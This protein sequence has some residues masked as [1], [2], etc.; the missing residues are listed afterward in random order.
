MAQF[1]YDFNQQQSI[2]PPPQET[3]PQTTESPWNEGYYL[4]RI[5]IIKNHEKANSRNAFLILELDEQD[6]FYDSVQFLSYR[7]DDEVSDNEELREKAQKRIER[8]MKKLSRIASAIGLPGPSNEMDDY[9][10]KLFVGQVSPK[11]ESYKGKWDVWINRVFPLEEWEELRKQN[12][13]P[14]PSAPAPTPEQYNPEKTSEEMKRFTSTYNDFEGKLDAPES[15]G[16]SKRKSFLKDDA[17]TQENHIDSPYV[18]DDVPFIDANYDVDPM[19]RWDP[20]LR[21]VAPYL[22]R[23]V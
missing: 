6:F 3:P 11:K 15:K 9:Q 18:E 1:A 19:F 5:H 8:D 7:L 20:L 10:G 23:G 22:S 4:F 14:A 13:F 12:V 17:K 21:K 16:G 2:S